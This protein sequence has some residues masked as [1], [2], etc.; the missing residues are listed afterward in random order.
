[1]NIP[2]EIAYINGRP[3]EHRVIGSLSSKKPVILFLHEGLGCITMWRDFPDRLSNATGLSAL[4]YSRFGYGKSDTIPLPRPVSFMHDEAEV[5]NALRSHFQIDD[6]FVVGHSDGASIALINAGS[7][8]CS[9]IRGLLLEAPHVFVEEYCL[10]RIAEVKEHYRTSDLRGKLRRHHGDNVDGAFLGW[11]DVWLNPQFRNWNIESYLS[12]ITVP[13]LLLQGTAD[14]Y[15]T[16]AQ[17]ESVK[18]GVNGPV[19]VTLIDRCGH[20]PHR[21]F[22]DE[23]LAAMSSF[24]S[25]LID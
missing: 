9:G 16:M 17:I 5:L 15:G 4:V 20:S 24:I 12:A 10:S 22:P 3:L 14:E 1:M 25:R 23:T 7:N 21:E 18:R 19:D 6:C 11:N 8:G 2:T 13:V